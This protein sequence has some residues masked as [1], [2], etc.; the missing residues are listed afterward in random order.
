MESKQQPKVVPP[1]YHVDFHSVASDDDDVLNDIEDEIDTSSIKRYH[2]ENIRSEKN[3]DNGEKVNVNTTSPTLVIDSTN[4]HNNAL[5]NNSHNLS[6]L[7]TKSSSISPPSSPTSPIRVKKEMQ[8]LAKRIVLSM[9]KASLA[10]EWIP[11]PHLKVYMIT[12]PLQTIPYTRK[13]PSFPLGVSL[14]YLPA[15]L[16][17]KNRLFSELMLQTPRLRTWKREM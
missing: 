8:P 7:L 12:S 10:T 4:V 5:S 11:S 9:K 1:L 14:Y 15:L 2:D 13:T 6:L 3:E 16:S 17:P